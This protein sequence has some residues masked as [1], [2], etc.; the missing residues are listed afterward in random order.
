MET[1]VKKIVS[2]TRINW[3]E[4]DNIEVN[5]DQKNKLIYQEITVTVKSTYHLPAWFKLFGLETKYEME[6]EAK[7]AAVD[8]DEFIR[9]A[10]LVVDLITTID[11]AT[12]NH[13]QKALDAISSLGTKMLDWIALE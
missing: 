8:P 12:G 3:I 5:C 7:L 13:I 1:E 11:N 4:Q 10:D 6:T 2:K 9:N